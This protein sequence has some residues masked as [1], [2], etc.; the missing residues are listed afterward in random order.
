MEE[1]DEDVE[2]DVDGYIGCF[3]LDNREIKVE[4]VEEECEEVGYKEDV[5]LFC[6]QVIVWVEGCVIQFG[7]NGL[8]VLVLEV[9]V[10]MVV[11]G[12]S[13]WEIVEVCGGVEV[14][15]VYFLVMCV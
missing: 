13:C 3:G 10:V 14:E 9:V 8:V 11:M 1:G 5:V 2:I 15:V 12:E 4:R 6:D 7:E